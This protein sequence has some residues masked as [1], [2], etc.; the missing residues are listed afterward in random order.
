MRATGFPGP[1]RKSPRGRHTDTRNL[2]CFCDIIL[3]TPWRN[4][5][6]RSNL[7]LNI[8]R[9]K[10][11]ERSNLAATRLPSRPTPES[12]SRSI[13]Q[14]Q[15]RVIR[16]TTLTAMKS[17]LQRW[18]FFFFPFLF[19]NAGKSNEKWSKYWLSNLFQVV[20]DP[21]KWQKIGSDSFAYCS[22]CV[23]FHCLIQTP[24]FLSFFF[25]RFSVVIYSGVKNNNNKKKE[26][27]K[28]KVVAK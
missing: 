14:D 4:P 9:E 26:K 2:C 28:K 10:E 5:F 24:K 8:R 1:R 6:P 21:I 27:K 3:L 11:R 19:I 22:Y 13:K 20:G 15:R 18:T 23:L 7:L 16:T 17:W 25:L 12:W